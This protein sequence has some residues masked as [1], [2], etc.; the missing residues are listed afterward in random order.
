MIHTAS[1]HAPHVGVHSEQAFY[2]TNVRGTESLLNACL[3]HGVKRF[4]Y[5]STTSLYG[6]AMVPT[7]RAVW[8]TEERPPIPRDIYDE[9]KIAA[10]HACCAAANEAL[11]RISLRISRCFP[12][13]APLMTIYRLYRGVDLRD[14]ANAHMLSLSTPHSEVEAF[15]ISAVSPFVLEDT[16]ALLTHAAEVMTRYYPWAPEAFRRRGWLLPHTID[17]V[18]VMEKAQRMLSYRPEHNFDAV[19]HSRGS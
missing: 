7:D 1:L 18:Y 17:R 3:Q 8:V 10:E 6:N 12:E 5:T 9:T 14:V 15:N 2:E 11:T 4:I 13:P 16:E 19:L